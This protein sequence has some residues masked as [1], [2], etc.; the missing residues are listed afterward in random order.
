MKR[1]DIM[2][3][4]ETLGN[5]TDSTI[6]QISAIAFNIETGEIDNTFNEIVDITKID[7]IKLTGS[8]LKWWFN[9]DKDLLAK[10]LNEGT[11]SSEEV[12]TKFHAWITNIQ[13]HHNVGKENVYFWGKGILFDNKMIQHQ[14][15]SIGLDYPIFY[16][17]DRDVRTLIELAATKLNI[18]DQELQDMYTDSN[19]IA[20]DAFDDVKHQINVAVNCYKI[21]LG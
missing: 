5:K 10:I 13:S 7:N 20:H 6:I 4:I 9:T 16:R 14:L 3:D 8:T 1:I 2:T 17:N 18:T 12:L 21:L 19:L 11:L 15:E